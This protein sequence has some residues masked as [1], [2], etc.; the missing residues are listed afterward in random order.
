MGYLIKNPNQIITA[1][2]LLSSANLLTPGYIVDIPEYPKVKGYFW[3]VIYMNG[4]IINGTIPYTGT[5]GIHIQ[6]SSA[7]NPQLRF[8]GIYMNN[9]PGIWSYA[10]VGGGSG[11]QYAENDKLQIH[12]PGTLTLGDTELMLYIGANL[13]K[14]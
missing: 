2:V 11:T 12:N 14:Y 3:N 6:A 10:G 1:K 4:E 5:S 8:V 9:L 13:I 7:I